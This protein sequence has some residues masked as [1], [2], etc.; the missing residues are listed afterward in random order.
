MKGHY[1]N[2]MGL[3]VFV[4]RTIISQL[5]IYPTIICSSSSVTVLSLDRLIITVSFFFFFDH[6]SFGIKKHEN[7]HFE[8]ILYGLL[9]SP[10]KI[11]ISK[12]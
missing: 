8:L 11:K 7:L 2:R 6:Y 1:T 10:L 9:F 4:I 3:L 12:L 5:G